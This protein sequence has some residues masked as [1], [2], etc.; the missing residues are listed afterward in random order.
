M[1]DLIRSSQN[2]YKLRLSYLSCN[3]EISIGTAIPIH[4]FAGLFIY[5]QNYTDNNIGITRRYTSIKINFD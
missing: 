5:A 3:S 1:R 4:F 2:D